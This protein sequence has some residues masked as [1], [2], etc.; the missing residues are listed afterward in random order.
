MPKLAE[1]K[2]DNNIKL[3]T[4]Q[5][6]KKLKSSSTDEI[7]ILKTKVT[8]QNEWNIYIGKESV[9]VCVCEFVIY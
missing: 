5:T 8:L 9:R 2:K 3:K 4:M 6:S 7:N 1:P